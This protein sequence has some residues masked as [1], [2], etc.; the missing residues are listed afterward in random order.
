[1]DDGDDPGSFEIIGNA[2]EVDQFRPQQR[3]AVQPSLK[4]SFSMA[5]SLKQLNRTDADMKAADS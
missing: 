1:M 5:A 2:D 4:N 3:Q